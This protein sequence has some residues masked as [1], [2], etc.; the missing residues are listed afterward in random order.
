MTQVPAYE[1]LL[2]K[3]ADHWSSVAAD[4][5]NPQ[6]WHDER[7]FGIFFG[8]EYAMLVDHAIS[9][10][11]RVLELGCGEGSLAVTIAQRGLS[12]TAL[13][14]SEP[15][16]ARARQKAEIAGVA[17]QIQFRVADLNR[18]ELPHNTYSCVVAHDSLHH[19]LSLDHLLGQVS[20]ALTPDG[21]LVVMDYVGMGRFRKLL[22]AGLF[23]VLPTI[24][25]YSEKWRLRKRLRSFLA[26]E[27]AKRA[28]LGKD[29][30]LLHPDS[31]FEEISQASIVDSIEKLFLIQQ[32]LSFLP[33]WFYFAPK[34][35]VPRRVRYPFARFLR[36]M[37][38]GLRLL[39]IRGAYCFIDARK[40][41]DATVTH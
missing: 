30:T 22:A 11:P 28:A 14:L 19:I 40:H 8:R 24:Q 36:S 27:A 17:D 39:G 25:P 33:F 31:P 13:D 32:K 15:R 18:V 6:I 9:H 26:S 34:I 10:G 16:I 7:L 21:A 4:P 37:D 38:S 20:N 1:D 29:A 2:L 3:E 12:V 5:A 23:A 35:R 41:N